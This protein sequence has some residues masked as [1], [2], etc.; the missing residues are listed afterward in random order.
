MPEVREDTLIQIHEL[1][2]IATAHLYSHL[3]EFRR[4]FILYMIIEKLHRK[5]KQVIYNAVSQ[6][7]SL[8]NRSHQSKFQ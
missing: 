4:K 2:L 1:L 8:L 3:R 6:Y 5:Y 7:K